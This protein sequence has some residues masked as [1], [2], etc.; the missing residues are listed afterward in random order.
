MYIRMKT[1]LNTEL[2]QNEK[3][4]ITRKHFETKLEPIIRGR[5]ER[6]TH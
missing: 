5:E 6:G 2:I 3:E 1:E 4:T